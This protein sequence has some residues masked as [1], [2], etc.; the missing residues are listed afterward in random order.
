LHAELLLLL[1]V[2]LPLE[3]QL[4]QL[5]HHHFRVQAGGPTTSASPS[6]THPTAPSPTPRELDP[7]GRLVG[8]DAELEEQLEHIVRVVLHGQVQRRA[9]DGRHVALRVDA[10]P[11]VQRVDERLAL[12]QHDLHVLGH[13]T[14]AARTRIAR[15]L[16]Q[17]RRGQVHRELAVVNLQRLLD[18]ID[19][20]VSDGALQLLALTAQVKDGGGS[21]AHSP[22]QLCAQMGEHYKIPKY[23]IFRLPSTDKVTSISNNT[24]MNPLVVCYA[25]NRPTSLEPTEFV[26]DI[27]YELQQEI[28]SAY[29][30]Y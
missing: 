7:G 22:P 15:R 9:E 30:K 18:S 25:C 19:I 6:S 11:A 26:T 3:M 17:E 5:L 20:V 14:V 29:V 12:E 23:D 1:Q 8:V 13:V 27:F 21:R 2:Q 16:V 24:N 4:L 28:N 10:L